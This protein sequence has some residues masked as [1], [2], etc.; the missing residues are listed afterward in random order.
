MVEEN[1]RVEM[2]LVVGDPLMVDTVLVFFE[3][4][5]DRTGSVVFH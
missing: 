1:F 4:V 5:L 2:V 3:A